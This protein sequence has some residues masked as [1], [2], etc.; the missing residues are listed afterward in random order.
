M[1]RPGFFLVVA[2]AAGIFCARPVLAESRIALVIGNSAYAKAPL[3]TALADGGLVAEALNGIGFEIIEGADAGQND[4]RH[5]FRDFLG[6]I[7]AAGPDTIAVVYFSGY[8]LEFEGENYLVPIDA[9]LKRGSDIPIEAVRLADLMRPL[10]GLPARAQVIVLDAARPLF[11]IEG[12]RL[13]RGLAAVAPPRATLV[14]MASGP[15]TIAEDGPGPYGPYALA[16]AEML[17]E[18]GLDLDTLFTRVRARTHQATDGRQIPWHATTLRATVLVPADA[19][20]EAGA[21]QSPPTN[22]A[23]RA[24][25]PMR[26]MSADEAYALAVEQDTLD[27]YVEF[28]LTYPN[29]PYAPRVL[30]IIRARREAMVWQGTVER[31]TPE[32]YWT[33]LQRYPQGDYGADAQARLQQLAG[34]IEAPV[35]FVPVEMGVPAALANEPGQYVEPYEVYAP[36]PPIFLIAPVPLLFVQLPPPHWRHFHRLPAVGPLPRFHHFGQRPLR[37]ALATQ[38]TPRRAPVLGLAPRGGLA[39]GVMSR[40]GP[41][42]FVAAAPLPATAPI[43]AVAAPPAAAMIRSAPPAF[44]RRPPPFMMQRPPPSAVVHHAPQQAMVRQPPRV[45]ARPMA[46]AIAHPAVSPR[47][48]HGWSGRSGTSSGRR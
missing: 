8:G 26:D 47:S 19:Q 9:R 13:A 10:A 44:V 24:L 48:Q 42:N 30:S 32:A 28:V 46:P 21:F 33:Y 37:Q 27:A 14:A 1:R 17:R 23:R 4:L 7:E 25:R 5:L 18:P 15:G 40:P 6:K 41:G 12:T 29:S 35:D 34:P 2:F 39:P 3:A 38:E 16:I 45:F 43:G 36:P 20:P 11:M 22:L 31:N